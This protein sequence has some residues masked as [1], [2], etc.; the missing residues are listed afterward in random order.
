VRALS[1]QQ[2]WAHMILHHGKDV[3]N[4]SWKTPHRGPF[5]I[6]AGKTI[7]KQAL[8]M[9]RSRGFDIPDDLPTGG[10][11]GTAWITDCRSARECSSKWAAGSGYCFML[12]DAQPLPFRPASGSLGFFEVPVAASAQGRIA[13]LFD[14]GD[15][16]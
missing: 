7:D 6:H 9:L 12:R 13:S 1:I 3:E 16:E 11:V 15:P 10:I 8:A 4:R 14:E 5:L 2:P